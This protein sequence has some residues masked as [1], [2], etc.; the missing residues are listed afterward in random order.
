MSMETNSKTAKSLANTIK[1]QARD[2]ASLPNRF[3]MCDARAIA[4]ADAA[5]AFE[6]CGIYLADFVA[7]NDKAAARKYL[8]LAT[9]V[10]EALSLLAGADESPVVGRAIVSA[11]SALVKAHSEFQAHVNALLTASRTTVSA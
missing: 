7:T 11:S 3:E 6:L 4:F 5:T 1:S 8:P 9:K 2:L 10:S